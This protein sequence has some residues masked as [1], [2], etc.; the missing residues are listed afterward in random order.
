MSGLPPPSPHLQKVSRYVLDL[1][2][3]TN[4]PHII[5]AA[6]DENTDRRGGTAL[7]HL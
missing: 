7:N 5:E 2:L 3:P 4:S 1:D 6:Q